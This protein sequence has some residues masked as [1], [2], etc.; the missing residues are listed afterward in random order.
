MANDRCD[1][2]NFWK[3]NWDDFCSLTK[4][5]DPYGLGI[6]SLFKKDC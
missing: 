2:K 5:H 4:P 1:V 3:N 6:G